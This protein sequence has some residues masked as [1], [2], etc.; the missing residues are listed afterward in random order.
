MA[1]LKWDEEKQAFE[2]RVVATRFGG[3]VFYLTME[4]LPAGV[5]IE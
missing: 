3:G 2:Y 5:K 1:K 4:E